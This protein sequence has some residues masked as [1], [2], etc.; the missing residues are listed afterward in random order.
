MEIGQKAYSVDFNK[1]WRLFLFCFPVEAVEFGWFQGGHHYFKSC[2]VIKVKR[3]H[4][5]MA[6][7][8]LGNRFPFILLSPQLAP[9]PAYRTVLWTL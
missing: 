5:E 1:L 7:A 8:K 3:Q 2:W 6:S 4:A 9:F